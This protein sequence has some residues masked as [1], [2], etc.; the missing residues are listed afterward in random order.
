S[1]LY[2]LSAIAGIMLYISFPPFLLWF[3]YPASLALLLYLSRDQ[4]LKRVFAIWYVAS[5]ALNV[6]ALYWIIYLMR[7]KLTIVLIPGMVLAILFMS[8]YHAL[9]ALVFYL[10]RY[11]FKTKSQF[12]FLTFPLFFIFFEVLKSLGQIS[13]PWLQAG[14]IYGSSLSIIQFL[15]VGGLYFYSFLAVLSG[16][17]LY[18]FIIN[19]KIARGPGTVFLFVILLHIMLFI[20]GR[21]SLNRRNNNGSVSIGIV[22]GNMDLNRDAWDPA[23]VDSVFN[24]YR[25]STEKL[26][27]SGVDLVIWPETAMPCYIMRRWKYRKA[28]IQ[29]ADRNNTPIIFGSLDAERNENSSHGYDFYNSAFYAEPNTSSLKKYDKIKLVPFS[30]RLPFDNVF[31][32]ISRVDLGESDFTSGVNKTLF[33]LKEIP[34]SIFICYEVVYQEFIRE[35]LKNGSCFFIQITNDAWFK[36]SG[37]AAQHLNITRYRAVEN[38]T[39]VARCANTGFS[40]FIDAKGRVIKKTEIFTR[41]AISA[42]LN[43]DNKTSFFQNHGDW[44]GWSCFW[45][46]VF[47]FLGSLGWFLKQKLRPDRGV[48]EPVI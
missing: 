34:F 42:H 35:F 11:F 32:L 14:Y 44:A 38:R 31:P 41:R 23:F 18:L 16:T 25:D 43:L 33:Y 1:N 19:K 22:Q 45:G 5:L 39:P 46:A 6:L 8:L 15:S 12:Y 4:K 28:I 17:A 27:K 3:L 36:R 9:P 40:C 26:V 13:F 29:L 21:A 7:G 24:I 10:S 30:E 48:D 37:M 47:I 20:G 2:I